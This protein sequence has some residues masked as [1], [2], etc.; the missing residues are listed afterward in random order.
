MLDPHYTCRHRPDATSDTINEV[1]SYAEPDAK[2][3]FPGLYSTYAPLRN[4]R[5]L[6]VVSA[7]ILTLTH[8]TSYASFTSDNATLSMLAPQNT[9]LMD[10]RD[11]KGNDV[12]AERVVE[13]LFL[14]A[15]VAAVI[16]AGELT[17][18]DLKPAGFN[19]PL[20]SPARAELVQ[21][22][23]GQWGEHGPFDGIIP[24]GHD[25]FGLSAMA[26]NDAGNFMEHE[27]II[28]MLVP[29]DRVSFTWPNR[30]YASAQDQFY[31]TAAIPLVWTWDPTVITTPDGRDGVEGHL[32]AGRYHPRSATNLITS[33]RSM[34]FSLRMDPK[35]R[36]PIWEYA[37]V[38]VPTNQSPTLRSGT[39]SGTYAA[40]KQTELL[41]R[42]LSDARYRTMPCKA[43]QEAGVQWDGVDVPLLARITGESAE[44]AAK[45]AITTLHP[46]DPVGW[47]KLGQQT[48]ETLARWSG[49]CGPYGTLSTLLSG[50]RSVVLAALTGHISGVNVT[51]ISEEDAR[52]LAEEPLPAPTNR[53]LFSAEPHIEGRTAPKKTTRPEVEQ[54]V[55]RGNPVSRHVLGQKFFLDTISQS[56]V[57]MTRVLVL[58]GAYAT[59]ARFITDLTT[60]G[61]QYDPV[62]TRWLDRI[63][64]NAKALASLQASMLTDMIKSQEH[65]APEDRT[66]PLITSR[67]ADT[68]P[69]TRIAGLTLTDVCD[70]ATRA[71]TRE[72]SFRGAIYG[73]M[74][75][76]VRGAFEGGRGRPS[77]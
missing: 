72:M 39:R 77:R 34:T 68:Y 69:D 67:V 64:Q 29:T 17:P 24:R 41:I 21:N 23:S 36:A 6:R 22:F 74:R 43:E 11:L 1:Q 35:E 28:P 20:L 12:S 57:T 73:Q 63:L 71:A 19:K 56:D 42:D 15:F 10:M 40:S 18:A 3:F 65:L 7:H 38:S 27:V 5:A 30:A 54:T 48:E 55:R 49:T 9:L 14:R 62:M 58:P 25:L 76:M 13:T 70:M 33:A 37:L 2:A 16:Q 52:F 31:N 26:L 47:F 66:F 51:A 32:Y 61:S 53:M 46:R 8:P 50:T 75:R 59:L 4:Y 44:V 60:P 45:Y